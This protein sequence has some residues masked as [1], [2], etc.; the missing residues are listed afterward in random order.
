MR[1]LALFFLIHT[2]ADILMPQYFCAGEEGGN[3]PFQASVVTR[4]AGESNEPILAAVT[5]SDESDRDRQPDQGPHEEDC[6]C[7]CSHVLPGVGFG[8]P[9]AFDLI[10]VPPPS[11]ADSLPSPPL[12]GTYHP[13][14]S[15]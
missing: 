14:R 3:L 2:G 7:C 15:T 11:F 6:F 4:G 12:R 1:V 9:V 10:S 5:S 13:P 8:G